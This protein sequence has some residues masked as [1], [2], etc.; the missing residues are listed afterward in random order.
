[1]LQ[2]RRLVAA[3]GQHFDT[4]PRDSDRMLELGGKL[5]VVGHNRPSV[6]LGRNLAGALINHRLDGENVTVARTP[7]R[8]GVLYRDTSATRWGIQKSLIEGTTM[9]MS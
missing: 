6:A 7:L 5:P 8:W 3:H 1:M 2:H 4:M 9:G